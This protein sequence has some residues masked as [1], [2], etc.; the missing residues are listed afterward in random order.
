MP[1]QR[2]SG[3]AAQGPRQGMLCEQDMRPF[4]QHEGCK[5]TA[6]PGTFLLIWNAPGNAAPG[7]FWRGTPHH[8]NPMASS[9]QQSWLPGD[10]ALGQTPPSAQ[11]LVLTLGTGQQNQ[12][13]EVR[14]TCRHPQLP[15]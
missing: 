10:W 11:G 12:G 3:N 1:T 2:A 4:Q 5:G 6:G 15:S 8:P 14:T 13:S 9:S 7:A